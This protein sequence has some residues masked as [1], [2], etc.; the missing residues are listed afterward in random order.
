M[1]AE[2]YSAQRN[3]LTQIVQVAK[4]GQI[5]SRVEEGQPFENCSDQQCVARGKKL[6]VMVRNAGAISMVANEQCYVGSKC[7]LS[8]LIDRRGIAISGSGTEVI[9]DEAPDWGTFVIHRLDSAPSG[10]FY[11]HLGD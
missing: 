4:D 6:M 9:F 3:V 5:P 11:R 8:I 2:F 10:W 7:S 1:A